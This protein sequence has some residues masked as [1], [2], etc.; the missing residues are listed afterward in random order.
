MAVTP[1]GAVKRKSIPGRSDY[2]M[3]RKPVVDLQA[4]WLEWF[5]RTAGQRVKRT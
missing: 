3:K 2:G 1:S 4:E 5:N